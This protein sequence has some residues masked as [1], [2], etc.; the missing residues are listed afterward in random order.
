[1]GPALHGPG[2]HG[3]PASGFKEY[4]GVLAAFILIFLSASGVIQLGGWVG[5]AVFNA[6]FLYQSVLM[7]ATGCKDLRLKTTATGCV[8]FAAITLARYTDLLVSLLARSL[9]FEIAGA[10]LFSVG[11]YYSKSRK[12]IQRGPT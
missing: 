4:Y 5:M 8:L 10:A 11:I 6:L 2:N 7:I 9:V 12:Q 3:Y 1:M